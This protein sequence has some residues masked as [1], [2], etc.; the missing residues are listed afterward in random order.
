MADTDAFVPDAEFVGKNM[1]YLVL[2]IG[3]FILI[4][5][6]VKSLINNKARNYGPLEKSYSAKLVTD[7]IR[8]SPVENSNL[9]CPVDPLKY[10][11]TFFLKIDDYY[12]N[13]G[14]WKCIMIKGSPVQDTGNKCQDIS[15]KLETTDTS[16]CS[17]QGLSEKYKTDN[18]I[19][20]SHYDLIIL[21]KTINKYKDTGIQI[22]LDNTQL[23]D[24]LDII[25][26]AL[27]AGEDG[28][29][30]LVEAVVKCGFFRNKDGEEYKMTEGICK[31][32]IEKHRTYCN[33][34]YAVDKQVAR[35]ADIERIREISELQKQVAAMERDKDKLAG[36]NGGVENINTRIQKLENEISK[37]RKF[38]DYDNMCS[39]DNYLSKYP[40]IIPDTAELIKQN[41]LINLSQKNNMDLIHSIPDTVN[42]EGCYNAC[43]IVENGVNINGPDAAGT[44]PSNSQFIK[45]S[46]AD[47]QEC[48]ELALAKGYDYFG[49]THQKHCLGY[50]NEDL[51]NL[52]TISDTKCDLSQ[53]IGSDESI[54]CSDGTTRVPQYV[55]KVT[56][57]GTNIVS[58]CWRVLINR[59]PYQSPG[60]WL[61]P[62]VNN[63]RI[64]FTTNSEEE[65]H[66]YINDLSH[67][68][69]GNPDN[70]LV[71]PITIQPTEHAEVMPPIQSEKMCEQG[72]VTPSSNFYRESFDVL[73]IPINNEF[74][75]AI[76]VNGQSVEVY[77]N[78]ELKQTIKLFGKP[79]F[80][81]GQLQINPE[82]TP[83]LGGTVKEFMFFPEAI[84]Y[85]NISKIMNNRSASQGR[86]EEPVMVPLD[87]SHQIEVAHDHPFH[88]LD[89]KNHKHSIQGDDL[90]QEYQ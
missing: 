14:Y 45:A 21:F 43:D 42:L 62:F 4:G 80:N 76:I 57:V 3:F 52:N 27:K 28:I 41:D 7:S 38:D 6:M 8:H 18:G 69:K 74:H 34:V 5:F 79:T 87:H 25:C 11:F 49:L 20:E 31:N 26:K 47:Y 10:S 66:N 12:C 15:G 50:K 60:V 22:E 44:I 1:F 32:F 36:M 78:A 86:N 13:R 37:S 24:R 67:A 82:K 16:M 68:N 51:K 33:K 65:Y 59:Y 89:E 83:K 72:T 73:N 48:N 71:Q 40:G 61:H 81:T 17:T 77:V 29:N 88:P 2:A 23:F 30:M 85:R 54:T 19:T 63:I 39:V 64:V 90:P 58:D 55:S 56:E 9:D 70:R 75:L 84:D 53:R 46:V 35:Q